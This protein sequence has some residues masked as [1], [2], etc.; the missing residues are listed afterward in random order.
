MVALWFSG[1]ASLSFGYTG[2]NIQKLS[3]SFQL[4]RM[5]HTHIFVQKNERA[6]MGTECYIEFAAHI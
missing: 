3:T 2:G 4:I 1:N 6:H 5:G